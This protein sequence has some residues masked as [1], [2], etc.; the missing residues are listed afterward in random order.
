MSNPQLQKIVELEILG[1]K[2]I[3]AANGEGCL[4][5]FDVEDAFGNPVARVVDLVEWLSEE[6]VIYDEGQSYVSKSVLKVQA[7]LDE[8]VK[9][10]RSTQSHR[11]ARLGGRE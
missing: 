9:A 11:D 6:L 7:L 8:L 10:H 4:V 3:L 5:R 2:Y 1:E